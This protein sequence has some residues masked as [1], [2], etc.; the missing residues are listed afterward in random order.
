MPLPVFVERA[1]KLESKGPL[2]LFSR[3]EISV[4]QSEMQGANKSVVAEYQARKASGAKQAFCP[5][6]GEKYQ[7]GV[8]ELMAKLRAIPAAQART[9]TTTDAM[10]H[11]L[12]KRYPCPA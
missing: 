1:T 9:M 11:L 5:V 8:K 12:A 2:A 6:K 3:G 7:L 4:L 10:R